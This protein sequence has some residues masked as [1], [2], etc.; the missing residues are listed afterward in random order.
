MRKSVFT[1]IELLVVIAII[2]ILAGMLL[3][4][5]SKARAKAQ[6]IACV[7][8]L[9]QIGLAA[10]MY[11]NDNKEFFPLRAMNFVDEADNATNVSWSG[12]LHVYAGSETNL[13]RTFLLKSVFNCESSDLADTLSD[14]FY[15]GFACAY[16]SNP[17]LTRPRGDSTT[18]VIGDI[19]LPSAGMKLSK[20]E[21]SSSCFFAMDS[22]MESG[23]GGKLWG[24]PL[25]LD[26]ISNLITSDTPLGKIAPDKTQKIVDSYLT[27]HHSGSSNM[28]LADGH[29]ETIGK[30][31]G[32]TRDLVIPYYHP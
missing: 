16:T 23:N 18:T 20:V 9:K 7:N 2:A 27:F 25:S 14:G 19:K 29:T 10:S 3:P 32:L 1:L 11:I 5:V 17:M 15:Q 8:N 21:F 12:A 26:S 13:D 22:A 4:A 31:A 24:A 6:A 30:N 28:L